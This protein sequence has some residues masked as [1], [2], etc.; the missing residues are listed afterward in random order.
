MNT[1]DVG[2]DQVELEESEIINQ[3]FREMIRHKDSESESKG[4]EH[5]FTPEEAGLI[6]QRFQ[7][8]CGGGRMNYEQFRRGLGLLGREDSFICRIFNLIDEDGDGF[9][10]E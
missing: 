3:R 2:W 4:R 6:A 10:T 8:L 5:K 9:I 1:K 7:E